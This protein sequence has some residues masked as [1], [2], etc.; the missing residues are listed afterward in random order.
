MKDNIKYKIASTDDLPAII[1]VGDQLFDHE[2]KTN[3]ANEFLTDPRHHLV[4]A[5]FNDK[6]V[7]MA[8]GFHYIHPDKEP[9]LFIYEV[10]VLE[11]FQNQHIGRTLLKNLV[12]YSKK[13]GCVEAWVLTDD[14]NSA[15][16]KSYIAAGGIESKSQTIL[17]SFKR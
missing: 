6:V 16:R 2:I 14:S 7:G 3:R 4:L 10:A 17:I 8:S 11:E 12:E 9:E 1:K 15:A 13:L 5:Y